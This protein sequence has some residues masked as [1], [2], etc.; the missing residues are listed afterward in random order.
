MILGTQ[1]LSMASPLICRQTLMNSDARGALKMAPHESDEEPK[2]ITFPKINKKVFA[3]RGIEDDIVIEDPNEQTYSEFHTK[4]TAHEGNEKD[5][6]K[7]VN[8][9][10]QNN[11]CKL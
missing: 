5:R 3:K 1:S 9:I 7:M 11:E 10:N 2:N 6:T 8:S 4:G